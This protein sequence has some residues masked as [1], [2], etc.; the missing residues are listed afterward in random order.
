MNYDIKRP[1]DISLE[2]TISV[3][4]E[5]F[6]KFK[7]SALEQLKGNISLPGFRKGTVPS[8]LAKNTINPD[9]LNSKALDIS[10]TQSLGQVFADEKITSLSTPQVEIISTNYAVS[11]LKE[12]AVKFKATLDTYKAE[13]IADPSKFG[14]QFEP[15]NIETSASKRLDDF[16][17]SERARLASFIEKDEKSKVEKDDRVEINFEG[18]LNG[19]KH[20]RLTSKNYPVVLGQRFLLEDFEKNLAG[21]KKREKKKFQLT[22][23]SDYQAKEFAGKTVEFE[24]EVLSVQEVKKPKMDD[25]FAEKAT[26]GEF[27]TLNEFKS[28]A[29]K[30]FES[31]ERNRLYMQLVNE[32]HKYLIDN[33]T[34][35]IPDQYIEE[36]FSSHLRS[37]EENLKRNN[38]SIDLHIKQRGTTREEFESAEKERVLNDIRIF[39]IFAEIISKDNLKMTPEEEAQLKS[40]I[41]SQGEKEGTQE[42]QNRLN[43]ARTNAFFQKVYN[44]YIGK[45]E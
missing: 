4:K 38:Q 1:T 2:I 32:F 16:L 10:I 35:S 31:E 28:T 12:V 23:P 9:E 13:K 3:T 17:E 30:Y 8:F 18:F 36:R 44:K 33:S 7:D 22:F 14:K 27:K 5:E 37:L 19:V 15:K 43:Q 26:K 45:P 29:L 40:M 41:A 6:E 42:F 21:M 11:G 34:L 24:I 25:S 20:E 39:L